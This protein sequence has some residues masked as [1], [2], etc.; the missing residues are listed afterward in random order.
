MGVK[1]KD[2]HPPLT[3]PVKGGEKV[4]ERPNLMY[5]KLKVYHYAINTPPNPSQEG[6]QKF[7][8]WEGD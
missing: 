5:R 4:A 2:N 3:P 1:E 7:P 6:N 8:S